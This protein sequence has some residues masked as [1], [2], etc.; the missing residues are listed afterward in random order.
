MGFDLN[1]HWQE[2]SPWSHPTLYATKNL[3]MEMDANENTDLDFY[4]DIHAH[5]TLMNGFMY[6]NIY[7][8]TMRYERQAVFPKLFCQNAEDF[9]LNNTSFNK[10]AVKAGTGRRTL[11]GLLDEKSHCYTLEVSFYSYTTTSGSTT[12]TQPYNE[13][14]YMRLGQNL[15]KTFCDYYKAIGY[16][17]P[18]PS[19]GQ[20]PLGL[21]QASGRDASREH[22]PVSRTFCEP[23]REDNRLY[24]KLAARETAG[25]S[26]FDRSVNNASVDMTTLPRNG[27][28][29]RELRR[30]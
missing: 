22:Q 21:K 19:A 5:S 23:V 24:D 9:S 1:R 27:R 18:K 7:E 3:L 28:E 10:D 30:K 29:L 8:D 26:L 20:D 16:I 11:G 6:G 12:V 14:A 2:P 13:E 4:I 17:I 25:R 15:V